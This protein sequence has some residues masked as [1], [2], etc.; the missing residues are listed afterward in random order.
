[1]VQI[2]NEYYVSNYCLYVLYQ[3]RTPYLEIAHFRL[4]TA[5][6]RGS[7]GWIPIQSNS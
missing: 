2:Y 5:R 7:N 1:L 3:R 6:H 4:S